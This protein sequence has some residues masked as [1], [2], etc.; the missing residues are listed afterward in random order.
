MAS[1]EEAGRIRTLETEAARKRQQEADA[2]VAA[3]EQEAASAREAKAS[4]RKAQRRAEA[5][6]AA[7]G[8]AATLAAAQRVQE[9]ET[10]SAQK[11]AQAEAQMV[12]AS[13]DTAAAAR[14]QEE[15]AQAA[16]DAKAVEERS[17]R[18]TTAADMK[19]AQAK[20]QEQEAKRL[21]E[22]VESAS[23]ET[24]ILAA[25][26][27]AQKT[28]AEQAQKKAKADA[29]AAAES[30]RQARE[31]ECRAKT[32][33]A[34]ATRKQQ[35]ADAQLRT[36]RAAQ[37]RAEAEKAAAALQRVA[38]PPEWTSVSHSAGVDFVDVPEKC[39]FFARKIKHSAKVTAATTAAQSMD[40][41][42][43]HRVVRV[44]NAPLFE[45]YQR[46]RVKI[47]RRLDH[48]RAAGTAVAGLEEHTPDWLAAHTGFPAVIDSES[49]EFWLWHGTSASI[50]ITHPDGSVQRQETWEVLARHGF[51]ERVGGDSNGGLYGKGIYLADAASKA[52]Q[53]ATAPIATPPMNAAGHHC[54]LS[55]RV[56][57]G[58]PYRTPGSLQGQRRPP[59]N[60][61]TPGLPYDSVFAEEGVTD[62]G[63]GGG[64]GSQFHNEYV[65]FSK[66]QVYPE[67]V[68]WYTK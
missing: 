37:V 19:M 2:R 63:L 49:N 38:L 66:A 67:Y 21:T 15:A 33:A 24:E 39:G 26:A 18:D 53:Y 27:D 50:N 11:V 6:A 3:A 41:L 23:R 52:N 55:C 5:K 48:T 22:L 25:E 60:P 54:M 44:E 10:I 42:R 14:A 20:Q 51:D 34:A 29:A 28:L 8:L 17:K 32:E 65:V 68:I 59:N 57:M 43:V 47:R 40:R 9:A 45:S 30:Q 58:D 31:A 1:A 64:P 16:A 35:E 61:A 62:N 46:E 36:A 12:K 7:A 4:A 13:H 56:T